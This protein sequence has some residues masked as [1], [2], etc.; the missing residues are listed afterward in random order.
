MTGSNYYVYYSH[1]MQSL[2]ENQPITGFLAIEALF[3]AMFTLV[4]LGTAA[5]DTAKRTIGVVLLAIVTYTAEG[6]IVPLCQRSDRPHWAATVSNLLGVQ[7][8]STSELVL[9]SRL[10]AAQLPLPSPRGSNKSEMKTK[11]TLLG[12]SR[13]AIGLLWSVRRVG[14]PWQPKNIPPAPKTTSRLSFITQRLVTTV[15]MYLF[16]DVVVSLPPPP[17][18]M[19]A[20]EKGSLVRG[21]GGLTVGDIIFRTSMTASFWLIIAVLNLFMTNTGAIVSVLLGLSKPED[22][23]PPHGPFAEAYTVRRFWG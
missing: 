2:S 23:P 19:L 21:L 9:V 12:R 16:V 14:T 18:G 22:C 8:L 15:L 13:S 6:V 1:A 5:Q 10:R 3:L 7:F 17:P 4:V 11:S 20:V